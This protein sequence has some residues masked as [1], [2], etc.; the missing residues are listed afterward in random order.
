[1]IQTIALVAAIGF[2][3]VALWRLGPAP[4]WAPKLQLALTLAAGLF[5]IA[6]WGVTQDSRWL[7]GGV[8]M[9]GGGLPAY[10]A[11]GRT[12]LI[13]VSLVC[14]LLGAALYGI[15]TASPK[16]TAGSSAPRP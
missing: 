6:A 9:F 13:I 14:G 12:A 1:M 8:L 10:L 3:L 4:M 7:V 2:A 11:R 15:A 16:V 5:G